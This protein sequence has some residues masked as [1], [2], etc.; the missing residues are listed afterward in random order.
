MTYSTYDYN[1]RTDLDHDHP[2]E[3]WNGVNDL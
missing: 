1:R 2:N 3:Y